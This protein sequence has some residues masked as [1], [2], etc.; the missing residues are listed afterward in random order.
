[1]SDCSILG[2]FRLRGTGVGT[3]K[4]ERTCFEIA[5]DDLALFPFQRSRMNTF[6]A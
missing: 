2:E 4:A 6:A 1:M 5:F 3:L